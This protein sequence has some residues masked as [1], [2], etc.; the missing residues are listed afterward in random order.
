MYFSG[1][2]GSIRPFRRFVRS[3]SFSLP[4]MQ[5]GLLVQGPTSFCVNLS[6]KVL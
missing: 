6:T 5:S 1:V 3:G 4:L 2:S